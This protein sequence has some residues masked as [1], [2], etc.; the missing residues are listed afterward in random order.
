MPF[1]VVIISLVGDGPKSIDPIIV[2]SCVV[3]EDKSSE[4]LVDG[5]VTKVSKSKQTTTWVYDSTANRLLITKIYAKINSLK[6][7]LL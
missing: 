2:S 6:E 5:I 3:L 1:L 7:R 4:T